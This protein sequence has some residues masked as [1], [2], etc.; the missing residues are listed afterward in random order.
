M[1]AKLNAGM[2]EINDRGEA[3]YSMGPKA[4]SQYMGKLLD[5]GADL[6]GGCCGTTPAYIAAL[7]DVIEERKKR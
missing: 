1:I 6:I 2:P 4:F 5:A 7:H 3:I